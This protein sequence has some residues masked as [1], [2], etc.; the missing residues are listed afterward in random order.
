MFGWLASLLNFSKVAQITREE[1]VA[2][3]RFEERMVWELH[4]GTPFKG[5]KWKRLSDGSRRTPWE[6]VIHESVTRTRKGC[7]RTLKQRGL[8]VHYTITRD[9]RTEQHVDPTKRRCAHA[10]GWHNARSVAV[11]IINR[12]Y[13]KA[14]DLHTG[15]L[16][17]Q[18]ADLMDPAKKV[19]IKARWA[20]R[21]KYIVPTGDQLRACW[22]LVQHIDNLFERDLMA[23]PCVTNEQ[24]RWGRAKPKDSARKGYGIRAHCRWHH[25]DGLF[26]EHYLLCRHRGYRHRDALRFTLEKAQTGTRFTTAPEHKL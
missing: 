14:A 2:L 9:G 1:E 5:K 15:S 22:H 18:L 4:R 8:S 6:I 25:A 17:E 13:G 7:V 20:H 26:I 24:F 12:Y 19:V 21:R 10:G 16:D 23:F 11:E 3:D